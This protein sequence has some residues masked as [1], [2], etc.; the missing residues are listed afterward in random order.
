MSVEKKQTETK[1]EYEAP[2]LVL[3]G[4]L[5]ELTQGTT[6]SPVENGPTSAHPGARG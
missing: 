1:K 2:V 3:L 6:G 4:K 5:S